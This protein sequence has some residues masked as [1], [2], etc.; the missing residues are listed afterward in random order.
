M[1][2]HNANEVPLMFQAQISGRGQMQYIDRH[3]ENPAY[4][5]V[6]EWLEG[7]AQRLPNLLTKQNTANF[8]KKECKITW[9]FVTNSGSDAD[10]IRPV[11]AANGFPF[12]PGA[13]MKGAFLRACTHEQAQRYCG[14]KNKNGDTEPGILRFHGGY[15]RDATWRNQSLVDIVHPQ[16][17]W[18]VKNNTKDDGAFALISLYQPTLVFAISSSNKLD[19]TIWEEI[20]QIWETAL[21]R[22]IG[23]RTS[24]GYG[25]PVK[26]SQNKLLKIWLHGQGLAS[27]LLDGSEEFRP[28]M[29]KAALRGHTLRLFGG[30]TDAVTAE[31]LTNELWGGFKRDGAVAGVLGIAFNSIELELSEYR[32]RNDNGNWVSMP[33]Y[34]LEEGILTLFS[35]CNLSENESKRLRTLAINLIKFTL[36][37]SGFGKSWRRV[38]H[39]IFFNDYVRNQVNPM[40]GCHWEFTELSKKLYYPINKLSDITVFLHNL[41]ERNLRDWLQIKQKPLRDTPAPWREAWHPNNVEVWGRIARDEDDC[42]AVRWF[43]SNYNTNASIKGSI[44]T[45]RINQIGRI[46]HRMYPRYIKTEDGDL[47]RQGDEFIELLTIFPNREDERTRGFLEFLAQ[48]RRFTQLYPQERRL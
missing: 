21:E 11:I 24:A 45:G 28:N 5:W 32:Y 15:P 29:F 38:D 3:Q 25:Q 27:K 36:L 2:T 46:W 43:H 19:E 26:H 34:E 42:L 22:G 40:I 13:S 31:D 47:Q 6:D 17:P 8:R 9:R 41:R 30:V 23:S 33:T 16:Q 39:R 12:Y 10:F 1:M 14:S 35:T 37:L 18:Q 44:L 48:H 4:R 7:T 20:W